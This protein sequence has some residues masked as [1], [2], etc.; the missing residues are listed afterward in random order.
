MQKIFIILLLLAS[1]GL[2]AQEVVP[3][4]DSLL[5]TDELYQGDS[6]SV[7]DTLNRRDFL[8]TGPILDM[9]DSLYRSSL[10]GGNGGEVI[11]HKNKYG[12]APDFVPV[13]SDSVHFE[14]MAHLNRHTPIELSYNWQV[15]EFID[16]Y[17]V[18]RRNLT[19]RVLGLSDLYFPLF[20][21][22]LDRLGLPLELKYL[23]IVESAL[24]PTARSRAGATGL[25][26]F[27]YGTGKMYNLQVTSLVDDRSDPYKST[28]A[29]AEHLR[30]LYNIYNDWLLALAAYNSG[31]GNVNRAI[32]RS[33]G[34]TSFW[35]ISPFLPRE[36]RGYVPAFIAVTYIMSHPEEYNLYPVKPEFLYYEIDTVAIKDVLS[37]DQLADILKI[38]VD[39]LKFL[40]PSFRQGIIPASA[41]KKYFLRLPQQYIGD[42]IEKEKDLYSYTAE[43]SQQREQLLAQVKQMKEQQYHRV[44]KGE[45]LGSIARIYHCSVNDLKRWNN[46]KSTSLAIG[47]RLM[48]QAGPGYKP[49]V[50]T[51]A[52][53]SSKPSPTGVH[54]VKS[55]ETLGE[56]AALYKIS[57]AE[58]KKLNNLNTDFLQVNQKLKVTGEAAPAAQVATTIQAGKQKFIFYT[59]QKGDTL[60]E[61]A[62]K[63]KGVTVEQIRKWNN[64]GIKSTLQPGQK[65]I[66]GV[67]G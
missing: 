54:V 37:F 63:H 2:I 38:P 50:A 7:G 66:V 32:R 16:L 42:F 57:V 19:S 17:G 6:I 15:K 25:W 13:Y 26:Q 49:P 14:R 27:M 67:S 62:N 60:W 23:A 65:I 12:Y 41:E 18:R 20:E 28:V 47:Q 39:Q 8:Q 45:T 10:F 48:V 43:R 24:I 56:I 58:L 36:T 52:N 22:H 1:M 44:R 4:D 9:L 40:N 51:K 64:F 30:D 3:V 33:G 21:E 61:I 46:L 31:P 34:K 29:A 5:Y 53:I 59:V 11:Y 55:G 35:E